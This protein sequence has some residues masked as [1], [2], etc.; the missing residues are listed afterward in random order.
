MQ[1][2]RT[3]STHKKKVHRIAERD[4]WPRRMFQNRLEYQPPERIAEMIVGRPRSENSESQIA[5]SEAGHKRVLF[6]DLAHS[7]EQRENVLRR[8]AAVKLLLNNLPLG[9]ETALGLVVKHFHVEHPL[10]KISVA[11]LRRWVRAY[12]LLGLDGVV[13][14]KRGHSGSKPFSLELEADD[15]IRTAAAYVEYGIKGAAEHTQCGAGVGAGI[16][17]EAAAGGA[18]GAEVGWSAQHLQLRE[19]EVRPGGDGG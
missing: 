19:H 17:G 7:D 15:L 14:Q 5:N 3:C 4:A 12:Q 13:E 16:D 8:E 18:Q 9:K 6:A 10:F 1:S 2:L 11:S